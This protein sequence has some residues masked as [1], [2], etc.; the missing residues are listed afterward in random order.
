LGQAVD[1]KVDGDALYLLDAA[2][3]TVVSLQKR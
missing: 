2:G 1:F 3:N